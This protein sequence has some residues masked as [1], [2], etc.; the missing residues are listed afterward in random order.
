MAPSSVSCCPSQIRK[1]TVQ[2]QREK[3][4]KQTKEKRRNSDEIDI[5]SAENLLEKYRKYFLSPK[6]TAEEKRAGGD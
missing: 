2:D 1:I 5:V 3:S 6:T 4:P